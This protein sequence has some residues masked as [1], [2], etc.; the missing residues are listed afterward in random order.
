MKTTVALDRIAALYDRMG[1]ATIRRMVDRFYDIMDS[2][3]D[4]A[5]IRRL[6]P[7][8]LTESRDKLFWFLVGRFGGPALYAERRGQPMLKAR[9]NPFPIGPSERDQWMACME[10]SVGECVADPQDKQDLV[11][12]FNMVADAM[13][14]R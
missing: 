9:H 6:H 2:S 1:E 14:N 10:K 12:F 8:E 3:P 4:A 11:G 7:D 13:Q 5:G